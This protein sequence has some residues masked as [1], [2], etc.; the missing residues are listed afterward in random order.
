MTIAISAF[1]N[2]IK[3]NHCL[4]QFVVSDSDSSVHVGGIEVVG[5][6]SSSHHR[7]T[8]GL[9]ERCLRYPCIRSSTGSST[10][11]GTK[12]RMNEPLAMKKPPTSHPRQRPFPPP[13]GRPKYRPPGL[14]LQ[15]IIPIARLSS[16]RSIRAHNGISP[17]P[18]SAP[19]S[20][21]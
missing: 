15:P 9:V 5:L 6:Y 8:K 3:H 21:G 14:W 17:P 7:R 4:Q 20:S 12:E 11:E 10:G 19:L 2:R 16:A 18:C 1:N 13:R